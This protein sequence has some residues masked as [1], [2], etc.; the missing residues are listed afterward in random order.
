[1]VQFLPEAALLLPLDDSAYLCDY[2]LIFLLMGYS[3]MVIEMF[4][5]KPFSMFLVKS[6]SFLH[7]FS[8]SKI[9]ATVSDSG[10]RI[11]HHRAA[12]FEFP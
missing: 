3:E 11:L 8:F 12:R 4:L 2:L 7:I 1:V 9:S 10:F 5:R 6:H